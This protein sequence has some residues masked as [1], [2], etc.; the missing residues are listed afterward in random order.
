[1]DSMCR[2]GEPIK[3]S[4]KKIIELREK[5]SKALVGGSEK[6]RAKHLEAGKLMVRD[7]LKH[8]F[9]G[10]F[11]FEDG[12]LAGIGR[13]LPADAIVTCIGKVHGRD[14]AVIANDMTVKAGSWGHTTRPVRGSTNRLK[15]TWVGAPGAISSTT[16]S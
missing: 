10:D 5:V 3:M 7:R 6:A 12:L 11:D 9:D 15:V 14:V 8:L 2:T 16:R 4:N 13:D 1:M